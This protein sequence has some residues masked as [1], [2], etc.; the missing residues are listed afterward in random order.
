[1]LPP[2]RVRTQSGQSVCNPVACRAPGDAVLMADMREAVLSALGTVND[3]ELHRDLVS[4]GMIERA[5]VDADGVAHVKVNLTTPACPLKGK[6]EGDVREAVQRVPGVNGVVVTFGAMVR[7]A[8]QPALPGVKHVILVGSG[9]GGVGK[10]S[11][12]V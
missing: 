1:M 5:D 2:G 7:A 11:V 6:I 12:A 8:A 10:S 3:P 9:K 4:L